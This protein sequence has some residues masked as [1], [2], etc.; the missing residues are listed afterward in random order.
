MSESPRAVD[1]LKQYYISQEYQGGNIDI[2][3]NLD[4]Y[5]K[6]DNLTPDVVV[7][8]TTLSTGISTDS[9][10][11][12][13]SSTKGFPNE[14]GLLKINDEI[15]TYTGVTTNSFTG[16]KR[17]FSGI[18]SYHQELNQEELTFSTSSTADHLSGSYVQNLSSLFLQEFYKKLKYSLTPGL[19]N[20]DFD[21][22][23]NAGTF[24]KEARALYNAKGTDESFRILFNALYNETPKVVNLE[25]YLLKPSA[26]NYVRREVVIAEALSGDVTKL[27]GQTLFKTSDVNTSAS[28][29]E[30]EGFSRVGVALT[31]I[32]NYYKLSLFI[33]F[34]DSD[35]TIQGD[36]D[37]TQAT[38]CLDNVSIGSSVLSVD[39]T[40]GFGQTGTIISLGNTSINYTSKSVNQFFGCTG[41]GVS[42]KKSDEIRS[43][44]TYYGYEDGDSTKK[45]ELRLTGVLSDFEQ[46][47]TNLNI[48]EGETISVKNVGD[49]IQNPATNATFKQVFANSWIYNT[50]CRYF[51]EGQS[52]NSASTFTTKSK[53]DRSSLKKGDIVEVVRNRSNNIVAFNKGNL[54]SSILQITGDNT[55]QLSDSLSVEGA[56]DIRRKLNYAKSTAVPLEVDNIITDTSNLYIKDETEAYYASNS[57]P[58]GRTG[59][60]TDFLNVITTDVKS[61]TASGLDSL[62]PNTLDQYSVV[63]F[64]S[65]VPFFT[66]DEIYYKPSG[67]HYVGLETGRYYCEIVSSDKKK[68][69]VYGSRASIESATYIPLKS[70]A[71]DH[72]FILN[73]QRSEEIAAQK[74]LKKFPLTSSSNR[75]NQTLTEPGTTGMLVN[76]VEITNYKSEDKV[77]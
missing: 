48:N 47:S 39:S 70:V 17:G 15:I 25:E 64:P 36:F 44:N 63:S 35:S 1:F 73:S 21:P 28:I 22:N 19:E 29:S 23:L 49:F 11:I 30:V 37:I 74:T 72:K 41:I 61:A 56:I 77:Y 2:S 76:G 42:I 3:D 8:S 52:F 40:V 18:T 38:R 67:T 51:L 55:V 32:Q 45:V 6:L 62:V 53:I 69:R 16:V 31:T 65:A 5:L 60:T 34:D 68:I 26:A 9:D 24:I 4:Q 27:A 7:G 57:L 33:G 14:W 59:V 46:V 12:P 58:S 71:G 43:N 50:S 54:E 75:A 10:T 13:V 20:V 66:G